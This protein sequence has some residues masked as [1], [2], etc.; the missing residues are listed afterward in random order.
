MSKKN[1]TQNEVHVIWAVITCLIL[2]AAICYFN[3]PNYQ[4]ELS[5]E[6][7]HTF[8]KYVSIAWFFISII[9]LRAQGTRVVLF[10]SKNKK[11]KAAEK[12]AENT[13]KAAAA[14]AASSVNPPKTE[15]N[16]S[17]IIKDPATGAERLFRRDPNT[18]EYVSDDGQS[19][20]DP[21]R[22]SEWYKQRGSDRQWT[23]R[24]N[25]KLK[26]REGW[27]DKK[28]TQEEQA[29]REEQARVDE[30]NARKLANLKKYGAYT[31][32]PEEIK[33]IIQRDQE[34]EALNAKI[35]N[36]FGNSAAFFEGSFTILSKACDY[37]VDFL[38]E[39]TGPMGKHVVKNIYI[40]GR[41]VASKWSEAV[42]YGKDEWEA[43]QRGGIDSVV[44]IAQN[45]AGKK[46]QM[47]ANVG[48]DAL[49]GGLDALEKGES[50]LEGSLE[51]G[52]TGFLRTKA[53]ELVDTGFDK[54]GKEY[55]RGEVKKMDILR[56]KMTSG[57]I[58]QNVYKGIRSVQFANA[59]QTLKSIKGGNAVVSDIVND[60]AKWMLE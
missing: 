9:I 17:V 42:N 39:V 11:N 46:Y 55:M 19:V 60:T 34:L 23:D 22:L 14:K 50:F 59:S 7:V 27:L 53:G 18:G 16:D 35:Q 51:G 40:T 47:A 36:S 6:K 44:D 38:A 29:F 26:A 24:E 33:R 2:Y 28:L 32:D 57:E 8:A 25:E 31:D 12:A 20:L 41:N 49:K 3:G 21:D 1:K 45:Y 56:G 4:T 10:R 15:P 30:E 37:G 5:Q 43:I 48:G 52:A 13:A 58:S 54:L